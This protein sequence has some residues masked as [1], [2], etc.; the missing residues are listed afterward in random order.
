MFNFQDYIA[1]LSLIPSNT[2]RYQRNRRTR[3]CAINVQLQLS[4]TTCTSWSWQNIT[5]NNQLYYPKVKPYF[6]G[7]I[8]CGSNPGKNPRQRVDFYYHA[9]SLPIYMFGR[10]PVVNQ[11]YVYKRGSTLRYRVTVISTELC[12]RSCL[13][14]SMIAYLLKA[15]I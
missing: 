12:A 11:F 7:Q 10:T 15:Y 1:D 4:I 9:V 8:H 6:Y 13:I 5:N 3:H 14:L 2:V